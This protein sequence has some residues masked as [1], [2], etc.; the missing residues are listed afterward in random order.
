MGKIKLGRHLSWPMRSAVAR[1]PN[2]P[3]EV[4]V[5]LVRDE[6]VWVRYAVARNPKTPVHV[7]ERLA[8]DK[9][10]EVR[11]GVAGNFGR[12]GGGP[13]EALEKPGPGSAQGGGWE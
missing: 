1:D 13:R 9:T 11:C 4:L 3:V 12:I 10:P 6:A 7:L 5:Q 2:T 8:E